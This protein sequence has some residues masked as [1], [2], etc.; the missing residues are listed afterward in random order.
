MKN[1]ITKN[2]KIRKNI[3][4]GILL[5]LIFGLFGFIGSYS[6]NFL[7]WYQQKY[8]QTLI[9]S[10]IVALILLFGIALLFF[11]LGKKWSE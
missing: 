10:G 1:K 8:E 2:N 3:G 9:L 4:L 6:A 11:Y 7:W 5:G